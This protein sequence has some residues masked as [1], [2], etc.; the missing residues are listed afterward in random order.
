MEFSRLKAF[1][2]DGNSTSSGP[3]RLPVL[4]WLVAPPLAAINPALSYKG[5]LNFM[6]PFNSTH[7]AAFSGVPNVTAEASEATFRQYLSQGLLYFNVH[8]TAYPGG[9][10][11]GNFACASKECAPV[12]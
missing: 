2:Q 12:K 6:V 7:I 11:R 8:T 4:P 1:W 3:V 10:I 9:E 5:S